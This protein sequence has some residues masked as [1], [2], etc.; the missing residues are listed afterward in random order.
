MKKSLTVRIYR[1]PEL[2]SGSNYLDADPPTGGQ[3]D[4]SRIQYDTLNNT[5][6]ECCELFWS[7][8]YMKPA[9]TN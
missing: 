7:K 2:V 1:H 6:I 5:Y 3:H 8:K 9:T 4:E